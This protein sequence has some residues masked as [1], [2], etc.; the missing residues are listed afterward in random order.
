MKKVLLPL[1]F[2]ALILAAQACGGAEKC[3][4]YTAVEQGEEGRV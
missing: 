4:A 1:A 3:P 2:L